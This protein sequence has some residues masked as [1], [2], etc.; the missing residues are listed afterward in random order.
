[1]SMDGLERVRQPIERAGGLPNRHYV[2][3]ATYADERERVLF[4]SW[5]GFGFASDVAEPGD[6]LAV[7]LAGQPLLLVRDRTGDVRVFVNA[8][9]HRGMQLVPETGR[10]KKLRGMIRCPYHSWVYDL[11]GQLKATPHVGGPGVNMHD[12]LDRD[13]LGLVEVRS[14]VWQGVVFVNVSGNAKPFEVEQAGLLSRWGDFDRQGHANEDSK[15]Q[16]EVR[17]N[18]K[19]AVENCGESYHLP[20]IH[21]GLNSYS[22]LE[23]HYAIVHERHSGQGT[24]VYSPALS[25]AGAFVDFGGLP[26]IWARQAEYVSL[27]PNVLLGVHRDHRF[28]IVLLPQGP[29]RTVERIAIEYA[30]EAMTGERYASARRTNAGMW[31]EIFEEDI[32]VVEGMQ[33]GRHARQFDGGRFS[34]AM[35]GP[36]HAFH[37][38]VADRVGSTV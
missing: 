23:D 13:T 6:A 2:D 22:R 4:A 28:A 3:A 35:D 10:V 5:A 16:L 37:R 15:F 7:D 12:A 32:F 25:E 38:W 14:H 21:P 27:Y 18:W 20:W 30:A 1:M 9:R 26:A 24:N 33:R 34:P 31:K 17:A 29:E 19:L 8:C 36:T 11:D